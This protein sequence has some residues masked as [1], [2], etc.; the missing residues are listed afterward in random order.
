MIKP[1]T[2]V[3]VNVVVV[4]VLA[5]GMVAWVFLELIGGGIV[6]KP[7]TVTVDF[8]SSGGVFTNQEVTYRGVLVG[9]VGDLSLNTD[10]V[11]VDLLIEAEW[12]DE[13][14]ADV[15]ARVSSKSA[16]GEQF[17]DLTPI[18]ETGE[19]LEDGDVIPRELT[20]LPVDFQ[21]LLQSLDKVLADVPPSPAP[22]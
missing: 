11:N 3:A 18:A 9:K 14:P 6:N 5:V 12:E 20:S 10:G 19:F 13:I 21:Q 7:F 15:T 16:V 8:A 17:V 1:K 2:K 4:A 22:C